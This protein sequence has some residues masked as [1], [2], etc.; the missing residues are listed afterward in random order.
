MGDKLIES[1][2]LCALDELGELDVWDTFGKSIKLGELDE[3]NKLDEIG[4]L[5]ELGDLGELD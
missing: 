3:K 1:H 5:N 4:K 2:E